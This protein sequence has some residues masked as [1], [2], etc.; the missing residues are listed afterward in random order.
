MKILVLSKLSV[1]VWIKLARNVYHYLIYITL[2]IIYKKIKIDFMRPSLDHYLFIKN[3]IQ[4]KYYYSKDIG[5]NQIKMQINAF[6]P[7]SHTI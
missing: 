7:S 6:P 2:Y 3:L 4:L 5:K 1:P